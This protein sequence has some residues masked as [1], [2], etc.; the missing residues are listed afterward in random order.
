MKPLPKG[1][2]LSELIITLIIGTTVFVS[3]TKVVMSIGNQEI[4]KQELRYKSAEMYNE[5]N[6]YYFTQ[7]NANGQC[8]SYV[9]DDIT[10]GDII[11]SD[12]NTNLDLTEQNWMNTASAEVH[13][14][15]NET[16]TV[17]GFDITLTMD[18][19]VNAK[20]F[21][22]LPYVYSAVGNE[23]KFKYPINWPTDEFHLMY[24]DFSECE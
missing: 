10:I 3:L 23:L 17:I 14:S 18:T 2:V 19:D 15:T 6:G 22:R 1:L 20:L 11:D 5:A 12:L 7:F 16:G 4:R 21:A 13:Y 24:A 8:S 9:P